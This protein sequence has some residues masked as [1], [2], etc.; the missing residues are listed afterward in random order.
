VKA[1]ERTIATRFSTAP[2]LCKALHKKGHVERSVDIIR[3]KAFSCCI[4]FTFEE[5]IEHLKKVLTTHNK[6]R[7]EEERTYLLPYPGKYETAEI[8][9]CFVDKYSVIFYLNNKY[10]VP[11]HLVGRYICLKAYVGEVIL[12]Y[13]KEKIAT[14]KR[15]YGFNEWS[16]SI[17]HYIKTITRKPGALK[18]SLALSQLQNDLKE[19]YNKYFKETPKEFI[20]LIEL[21]GSIGKDK[22]LNKIYELNSNNISVSF[23][24][25]KAIVLRKDDVIDDNNNAIL[26]LS[27][28]DKLYNIGGKAV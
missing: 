15:L 21:I 24:N 9:E 19:I 6:N 14:H 25:I 1:I 13:E 7:L 22:V 10:S 20:K 28:Y 17:Y 27:T 26:M 8:R 12:L 11:D 18:G 23:D 3:R 16:I 2:F 5:A 4:N